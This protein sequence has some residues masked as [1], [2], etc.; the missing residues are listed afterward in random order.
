MR[1]AV[2]PTYPRHPMMLAVQALTVNAALGGRLALGI[3]LSREIVV[4]DMLGL[5]FDKPA[6]ALEDYLLGI[7][8][9]LLRERSV[10]YT[11]V[12]MRSQVG[13][14]LPADAPAPLSTSRP[15]PT[16]CSPWPAPWPTAPFCG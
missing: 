2:V 7:L 1:L 6:V 14:Q 8:G 9:P 10:Q 11:G 12:T 16:A 13:L 5:S 15:W 3:G 4:D